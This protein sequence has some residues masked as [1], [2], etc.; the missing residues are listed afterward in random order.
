M[1]V[2]GAVPRL[3]QQL[4]F[5]V[6]FPGPCAALAAGGSAWLRFSLGTLHAIGDGQERPSYP[7]ASYPTRFPERRFPCL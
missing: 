3:G 4:I 7:L 6:G 1:E 2:D 5:D